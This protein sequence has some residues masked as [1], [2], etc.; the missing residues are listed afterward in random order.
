[1][2]TIRYE[3]WYCTC[4]N[5]SITT[6]NEYNWINYGLCNRCYAQSP[7]EKVVIVRSDLSDDEINLLDSLGHKMITINLVTEKG[8]STQIKE[9]TQEA[10]DA[11]CAQLIEDGWIISERP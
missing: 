10:V 1:M 4:C 11:V 3:G 6:G 2:S 8:D 7:E 5:Q 9:F